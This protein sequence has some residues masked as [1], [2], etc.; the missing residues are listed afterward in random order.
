MNLTTFSMHDRILFSNTVISRLIAVCKWDWKLEN[1]C[2]EQIYCVKHILLNFR[3]PYTRT[4]QLPN[5]DA[6]I[7]TS[8]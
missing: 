7:A 4:R 6:Q 3:T 1:Y 2:T 5:Y 8:N